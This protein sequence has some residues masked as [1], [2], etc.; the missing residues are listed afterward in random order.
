MRSLRRA[1]DVITFKLLRRLDRDGG[2][3]RI[4]KEYGYTDSLQF[5]TFHSAF[6][7]T[8]MGQPLV[9]YYNSTPPGANCQKSEMFLDIA[10][11]WASPSVSPS[12][13]VAPHRLTDAGDRKIPSTDLFSDLETG[14]K[15]RIRG[16]SRTRAIPLYT[17]G[18]LY[19]MGYIFPGGDVTLRLASN[20]SKPRPSGFWHQ[21]D[22]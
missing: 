20:I 13:D 22:F 12:G 15:Y 17:A 8:T 19:T 5:H 6:C 2:P 21:I 7:S 18:N 11:S 1:Q 4:T 9:P 3:R 10:S 16:I 14:K